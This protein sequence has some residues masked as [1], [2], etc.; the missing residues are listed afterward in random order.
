MQS[1]CER[2]RITHA[3]HLSGVLRL[4]EIEA[5]LQ[6]IGWL[7]AGASAEVVAFKGAKRRIDVA[8]LNRY[9]HVCHL[10]EESRSD[11]RRE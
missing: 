3:W 11:L 1:A 10:E 7:T 2:S 6:T 4:S 9:C 5:G 8:P